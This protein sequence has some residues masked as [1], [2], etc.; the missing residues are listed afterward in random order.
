MHMKTFLFFWL[1]IVISQISLLDI[2]FNFVGEIHLDRFNFVEF[3]L[4]FSSS[5]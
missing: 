5:H 2:I 3:N 4:P 1:L